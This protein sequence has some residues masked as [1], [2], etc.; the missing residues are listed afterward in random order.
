MRI[1]HTGLVVADLMR[2]QDFLASV[3]GFRLID[4]VAESGSYIDNML[5]LDDCQVTTSRLVDSHG[6]QVELLHFPNHPDQPSWAGRVNSTGFTH[7]AL[8]VDDIDA[9]CQKI[10][11]FGG[12]LN[13]PPQEVGTLKATYARGPEGVLVEL[14]EEGSFRLGD[15]VIVD[16]LSKRHVE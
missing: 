5:E 7:I 13:A 3:L 14:V 1:R 11:E 15:A 4:E 10:L 16:R 6:N 12:T 8:T 9:V 2:M